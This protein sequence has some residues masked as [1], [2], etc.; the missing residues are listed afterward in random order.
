MPDVPPPLSASVEVAAPP[1]QVW[2]LVSDI[3]R[4]GEFSPVVE[5]CWWDEGHGLAVGSSFT[6]R[7]VTPA[8]TW[9][10]RCR[11]VEL[12]PGRRFAWEVG[13]GWVRWAYDVE[14][15]GDGTRLTESW[16]FTPVGIAGFAER[17][18]ERADAEVAERTAAA[19]R[20]VPETLEAI[21]R[22][23]EAG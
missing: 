15:A 4:T 12:E 21:R 22:A 18:G 14:P 10:T 3:T 8:R 19:H 9:E 6:G 20:T 13:A 5:A 17:Y 2:E 11:V 1:Q 16:E 7:N 23:A